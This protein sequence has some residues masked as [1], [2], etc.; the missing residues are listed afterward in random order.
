MIDTHC[1]LSEFKNYDEILI[2]AVDAGILGVVEVGYDLPSSIFAIEL[3]EKYINFVYPVIGI[4]PHEAKNFDKNT[5]QEL[6]R[7]LKHEYHKIIAIG[8]IGLDFYKNYSPPDKQIEVFKIQLE[9]AEKYN[10]PVVIHTRKA[11][12]LIFDIIGEYDIKAGIMHAFSGGLN[13]LKCALEL[14]FYISFCGVL[15]YEGKKL[16]EVLKNTP[17]DKIL[18]ETDSPYITPEPFRRRKRNEPAF[19]VYT[20][21]K[22][23]E[24]LGLDFDKL[25]KIEVK[26]FKNFL[27]KAGVEYYAEVFRA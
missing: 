3:S 5:L 25:S 13:E 10:K 6:E 21:K 19:I 18:F 24:I 15:T 16:K 9:L 12:P 11:F 2:R 23:S 1:H 20:I 22:A 26:N 27:K 8:E 7:I 17:V 4:H 14:G